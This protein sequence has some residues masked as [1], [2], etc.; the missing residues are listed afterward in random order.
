MAKRSKI[1]WNKGAQTTWTKYQRKE[2]NIPAIY[3]NYFQQ[4]WRNIY[5]L[6]M[7]VFR[8]FGVREL[9]QRKPQKVYSKQI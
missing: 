1:T 7:Y 5:K 9:H 6:E 2:G 8:N 4:T 3:T